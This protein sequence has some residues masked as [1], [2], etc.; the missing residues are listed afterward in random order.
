[1]SEKKQTKPPVWYLNTFFW[2]GAILLI[3][4]LYG[5]PFLGGDR[6]I[7]DPG[8]KREDG[9]F[10]YYLLGGVAMLANGWLS[11]RQTVLAFEEEVGSGTQQTVKLE[12]DE[13]A[14]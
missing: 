9:L 2:I 8:Q 3:L 1:M 13:A 12:T 11:H 7:R 5:L 4:G 6:A 10:V 14:Q